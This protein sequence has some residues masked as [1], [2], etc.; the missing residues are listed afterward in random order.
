[1]KK[2][3]IR[4]AG[5]VFLFITAHVN[6]ASI[7][8]PS[9]TITPSSPLT[10]DSVFVTL[11]GMFASSGYDVIGINATSTLNHIEINLDTTSPYVPNLGILT[12][13]S[14]GIDLGVL[15][16][17]L[18]D[19]TANFYVDFLLEHTLVDTFTV[20]AVPVPAAAWLFG[21]GLIG[22]VGFARRKKA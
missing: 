6:A 9:I 22:L 20:S 8:S 11:S 7:Y 10:T 12:S 5:M 1:M 18:Y 21:S 15:D 17:G 2:S 4:I 16:A 13:F 3:I 14:S 19:V